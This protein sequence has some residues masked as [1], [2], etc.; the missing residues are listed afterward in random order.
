LLYEFGSGRY[1]RRPAFSSPF[2]NW[3]ILEIQGARQKPR[4]SIIYLL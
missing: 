4:P 1:S 2:P 3:F